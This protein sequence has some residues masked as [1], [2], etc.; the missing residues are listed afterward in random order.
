MRRSLERA[1]EFRRVN[2]GETR[3]FIWSAESAFGDAARRERA[4]LNVKAAKSS[5]TS[6]L[7]AIAASH[8]SISSK[9]RAQ[10]RLAAA[11][12]ELDME[13]K[14]LKFIERRNALT[15]TF[16]KKT[17]L[18]EN[19]AD[20]IR[21][22]TYLEVKR[23]SDRRSLL[24]KWIQQ[25]IPLIELELGVNQTKVAEDDLSDEAV[26]SSFDLEHNLGEA[27]ACKKQQRKRTLENSAENEL[28]SKRR[29]D[30]N[31][32]RGH[33]TPRR[34]DSNS[35]TA[36]KQ[37]QQPRSTSRMK[38]TKS[39]GKKHRGAN[40]S[41]TKLPPCPAGT[42]MCRSARI[43]QRD[44]KS[45]T[46]VRTLSDNR[47]PSQNTVN[48]AQAQALPAKSTRRVQT[49]EPRS[50]ATRI[51]KKSKPEKGDQHK[52]SK[53]QGTSKRRGRTRSQKT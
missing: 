10:K 49:R 12:F 33:P 50:Q 9:E 25:Q 21:P 41:V 44:V 39:V 38:K 34:P 31:G 51:T 52:T 7:K 6:A 46:P 19:T 3:D 1:C 35:S 8:H 45:K 47:I 53:P 30:D 2:P 43:L 15:Y 11:E 22:K 20:G 26:A 14:S 27:Q 18:S 36:T 28:P 40:Q 4:E 37:S 32:S 23:D 48:S 16:C 13:V 17:K 24:L 42:G 29:K 5:L